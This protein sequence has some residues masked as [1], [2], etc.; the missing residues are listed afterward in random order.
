MRP[1]VAQ[2]RTNEIAIAELDAEIKAWHKQ[3][4]MSRR[5]ATIPAVGVL[6]ASAIAATVPDP[7]FFRSGRE[8]AAWLGLVSR[9]NSS[10]GKERLGRIS[11]QG[12]RYIGAC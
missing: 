11:K 2:L 3:N 5:L 1:L 7:S 12:N 8:F 6:T 10:G 9:Q 4:E